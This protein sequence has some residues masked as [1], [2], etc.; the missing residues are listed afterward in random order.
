MGLNICLNLSKEALGC[1]TFIYASCFRDLIF[2]LMLNWLLQ[3][4]LF[5]SLITRLS[6][7]VKKSLTLI[8]LGS[9]PVPPPLLRALK[10]YFRWGV[11]GWVNVLSAYWLWH[12]CKGVFFEVNGLGRRFLPLSVNG[13]WLLISIGWKGASRKLGV[14]TVQIWWSLAEDFSILME[15]RGSILIK[16][17]LVVFCCY[18]AVSLLIETPRDDLCFASVFSRLTRK[19]E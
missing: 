18:C 7:L 13:R 17:F 1:S 15:L 2:W 19:S 16:W 5:S 8:Y 4:H 6:I 3:E 14:D 12:R 9:M 10:G 11:S